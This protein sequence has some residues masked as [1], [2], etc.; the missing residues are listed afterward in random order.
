MTGSS[1]IDLTTA[2]GEHG[3]RYVEQMVQRLAREQCPDG[4]FPSEPVLAECVH[5]AVERL[6]RTRRITGYVPVLAL[7]RV[8]DCIRSGTCEAIPI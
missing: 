1:W 7:R 2:G 5:D 3:Q 6:W 4:A 8:Q